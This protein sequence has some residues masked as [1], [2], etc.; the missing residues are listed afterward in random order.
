MTTFWRKCR[1]RLSDLW[2]YLLLAVV[3]SAA[4][5][6]CQR[7]PEYL[8]V[9]GATMGTYY[10]VI[11]RC[12]ADLDDGSLRSLLDAELAAVNAEMSTYDPESELSLFNLAPQ[13]QWQPVSAEL[14]SVVE[15]AFAISELSDGAFD[16]TV[17]PLVNAWGFGSDD[18]GLAPTPA[19]LASLLAQVDYRALEFRKQPPA[20][21]KR[22]PVAVDLSAIAKGHGVDRL[23]ELLQQRGCTDFLV[24]IGGEVRVQGSNPRGALWSIGVEVPDPETQGDVARILRLTDQS[25][26]TSG[27]YRN[28]RTVAGRRVSHTIDPRT[29]QPVAHNLASVTV[30]HESAAWADGLATAISVLGPEAGV[31]LADAMD[32][33]MLMILR[34]DS[35]QDQLED[36]ASGRLEDGSSGRSEDHDQVSYEQRYTDA[37]KEYLVSP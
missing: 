25:V 35:G 19:Q 6:G 9:S 2:R 24:D 23:A 30:V 26:A 8:R 17:G 11:S 16:V 21:R 13:D 5:T 7:A 3:L 29:G 32:L 27:D 31:N 12:S 20:L 22:L 10:S 37:M 15:A 14:L 33:P 36:A 4:A 1:W 18:G 34:S 28:F